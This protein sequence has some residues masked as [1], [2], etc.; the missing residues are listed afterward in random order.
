MEFPYVRYT[1]YRIIYAF[2]ET[3]TW[4]PK[5]RN[6]LISYAVEL[7]DVFQRVLLQI[8]A[9]VSYNFLSI[10]LL[11]SPSIKHLPKRFFEDQK[12]KKRAKGRLWGFGWVGV[13]S[14]TPAG[15]SGKDLFLLFHHSKTGKKEGER[16]GNGG[17]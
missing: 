10:P 12:R 5:Q 1:V 11:P 14:P 7:L 3:Q 2:L 17:I 4:K 15:K 16:G 13:L 9:A 8:A 6:P